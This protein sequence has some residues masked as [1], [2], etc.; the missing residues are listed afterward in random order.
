MRALTGEFP[1]G[2]TVIAV[3][4]SLR[5]LPRADFWFTLD[6]SWPN[7]AIMATPRAGVIYYAAV[8]PEYGTP[9]ARFAPMRTPPDAHVKYLK[10]VEGR[11]FGRYRAKSGLSRD[12]GEINTGNSAWGALQLALHM[13]PEKVALFGVDGQGDYF[14]GGAPRDLTTMPALFASAETDVSIVNGSPGSLVGCF[15][16]MTPDDALQWLTE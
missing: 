2:V 11:E 6:P 5:Y 7:R 15:P 10:R 8:P 4:G 12:K 13:E 14:Y 9:A 3:N 1:D 16:K